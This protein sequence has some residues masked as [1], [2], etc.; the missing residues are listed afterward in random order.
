MDELISRVKT[1]EDNQRRATAERQS[2]L[3]RICDLEDQVEDLTNQLRKLKGDTILKTPTSFTEKPNLTSKPVNAQEDEPWLFYI[4][5][6]KSN[7]EILARLGFTE[8]NEL[9]ATS[10]LTEEAMW[11]HV[12]QKLYGE[13]LPH[14]LSALKKLA[15]LQLSSACHNELLLI[16]RNIPV[17]NHPLFQ[18]ILPHLV[19]LA[20]NVN[21]AWSE[22]ENTNP[23]L[24]G[25]VAL[26]LECEEEI[27]VLSVDR[28]DTRMS[29]YVERL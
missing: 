24:L 25:R 4:P 15:A 23:D 14:K 12:L 18:H 7:A 9:L 29:L 1:L 20:E 11:V 8:V 26:V 3:T 19:T 16:V 28:G 2:L 22:I 5:A 13:E 17:S 10:M 21:I 6:G 27:R